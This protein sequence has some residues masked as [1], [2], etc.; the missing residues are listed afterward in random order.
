MIA[1]PADIVAI[2][3]AMAFALPCFLVGVTWASDLD[4]TRRWL[5]T[6]VCV[7]IA[8]S[9]A[10][11]TWFPLVPIFLAIATVFA[12]VNI[13][14]GAKASNGIVNRR[15]RIF[16]TLGVSYSLGLLLG[17]LGIIIITVPALLI[18]NRNTAAKDW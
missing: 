8:G 14:L 15:S 3:L 10:T 4:P 5:L 12:I 2:V 6:I 1:T 9:L 18:A 17:P 16:G 11:V 7:I 13:I